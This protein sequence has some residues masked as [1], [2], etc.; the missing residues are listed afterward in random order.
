MST[1]KHG[2]R[3]ISVHGSAQGNSCSGK[4][5]SKICDALSTI[6][7]LV[8]SRYLTHLSEPS[9]D[10][11]L[12]IVWFSTHKFADDDGWRMVAC[13]QPSP[14]DPSKHSNSEVCSSF[15]SF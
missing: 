15:L 10:K 12:L 4:N 13:G 1:A 8:V 3:K 11:Q 14:Y 5:G 2:I 6:E 9:S 7:E